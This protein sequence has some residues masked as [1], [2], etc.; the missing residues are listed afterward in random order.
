MT[1]KGKR[2]FSDHVDS[3]CAK[4]GVWLVKVPRYLSEM[5]EKNVGHDVGRLIIKAA[6]GKTDL[7]FKSNT[8]LLEANSSVH[9]RDASSSDSF[10]SSSRNNRIDSTKSKQSDFTIPNEHSFVIGDIRNQ[11]LAVLCEDKSGL[12]EDADICSGRLSIEGR[13]V[14]RADC[15][16]PQTADYM[17]M[18]IKQIERSCQPKRHVKQMEKAEVKF[19]PI[20]V[21]AE[22]LAREKQKKEGAKTVRADKD[23]VRQAMFHAFEKHQYYRLIDLQKL[24]NQPPGFVK[25]ILTEIAVYNTMPPHKSMWELKP[26]YRNYR[27]NKKET[28]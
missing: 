24:T 27:K 18:K 7:I 26:E 16:P 19:K 15:R 13:V 17:R 28:E 14:K 5:W 12:N 22:M 11:S 1:S 6:N 10:L 4:R 2:K 21:H 8:N 20:A 23:I 9:D 3:D 25:E